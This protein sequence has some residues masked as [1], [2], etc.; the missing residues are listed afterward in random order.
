MYYNICEQV[1]GTIFLFFFALFSP[2]SVVLCYI[3][4]VCF[5]IFCLLCSTLLYMYICTTIF[6]S[7][8]LELVF[9]SSLL[10]SPLFCRSLLR[11][12]RLFLYFLPP[13]L[14]I[15]IYVI[16]YYNVCEK[17]TGTIFLFFFAFFSPFSVVLCYMFHV[18]FFIFLRSSL[19]HFFTYILHLSCSHTFTSPSKHASSA[20]SLPMIYSV[21]LFHETSILSYI[22]K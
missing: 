5:F 2:F 11:V 14:N 3:F 7:K 8:S 4:H 18:C 19:G 12:P 15:N 21:L 22:I 1:T 17:G 16:M 10:C 20:H 13:V 9:I 6:V